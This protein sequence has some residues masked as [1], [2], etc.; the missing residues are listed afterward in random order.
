[1]MNP[2]NEILRHLDRHDESKREAA[3]AAEN[4]EQA[5][6]VHIG[7]MSERLEARLRSE[8]LPVLSGVAEALK[9]RGHH[10]G[11]A[12]TPSSKDGSQTNLWLVATV[13]FDCHGP[14]G[15]PDFYDL[16]FIGEVDRERDFWQVRSYGSGRKGA[17]LPDATYTPASP[18]SLADFARSRVT[19]VVKA[20]FPA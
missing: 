7:V 16:S 1:M 3:R 2:D 10:A 19:A 20:A 4:S 12:L 14:G 6:S 18:E 9:L 15:E 5:F 8:V 17:V 13:R 11:V